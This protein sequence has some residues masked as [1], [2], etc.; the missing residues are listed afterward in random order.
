VHTHT[1]HAVVLGCCCVVV[2]VVRVVGE[3]RRRS[4]ACGGSAMQCVRG[5]C[6][7]AVQCSAV[8]YSPS[9]GKIMPNP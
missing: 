1:L 4:D 3:V 2:V 5:G 7:G 6:G 8:V 9:Y